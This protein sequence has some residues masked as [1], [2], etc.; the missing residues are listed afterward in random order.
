MNRKFGS[1]GQE[2]N[3]AQGDNRRNYMQSSLLE[4]TRREY[5]K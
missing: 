4:E 2:L 1:S 3:T 5:F